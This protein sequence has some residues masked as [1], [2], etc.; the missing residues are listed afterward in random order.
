MTRGEILAVEGL[1]RELGRRPRKRARPAA[2]FLASAAAV[3]VLCAMGSRPA[4]EAWLEVSPGPA[5]R[6]VEDASL[7]RELPARGAPLWTSVPAERDLFF[8]LLDAEGPRPAR[9]PHRF[10]AGVTRCRDC[11]GE[12]SR[13]GR[14]SFGD[15]W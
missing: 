6:I 11:H 5:V 8:Q 9:T 4:R 15:F 14:D 13:S 7:L 12:V 2:F 10:K 1:L 3:L